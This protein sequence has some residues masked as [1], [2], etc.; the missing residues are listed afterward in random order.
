MAVRRNRKTTNRSKSLNRASK[1]GSRSRRN[2]TAREHSFERENQGAGTSESRTRRYSPTALIQ[3]S[4]SDTELNEN[5]QA[6][7][8]EREKDV[9]K[10]VREEGPAE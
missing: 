9:E 6:G 3:E 1:R 5:R 8:D 4:G 10:T 2:N 7:E